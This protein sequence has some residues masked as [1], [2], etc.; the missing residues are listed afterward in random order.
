MFRKWELSD[1]KDYRCTLDKLVAIK[2]QGAW[3][4]KIGI[5]LKTVISSKLGAVAPPGIWGEWDRYLVGP[6]QVDPDDTE[7]V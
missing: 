1:I 5:K 3:G 2:L 4:P 6:I 7:D